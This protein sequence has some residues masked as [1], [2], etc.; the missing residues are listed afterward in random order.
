MRAPTVKRLLLVSYYYPPSPV[1]GAV[2]PSKFAAY[3]PAHGWDP[4][5]VTA[6][7]GGTEARG[8][9][10]AAVHS[11]GEWPHPLK[12]YERFRA[13]RAARHGFA[14]DYSATLIVPF[15]RCYALERRS[16]KQWLLPLFW[17]PD[18]EIGWLGPALLHGLRLIRRHG[19]S[20]LLTTGPPFTCHLVGLLLKWMTGVRWVA[21][22]RDPWSMTHKFPIF[23]NGVT[24]ALESRWIRAVMR[25]ADLVLSVTPA[26]TDEARKDHPDLPPER[27]A[28]LTSGFDAAELAAIQWQ[29]P[30]PLPVIV[31]YFGTFYHGRTP[32]PFLR[33]VKGLLDD[34]TL[35][36]GEMAVRFVGQVSHADGRSITDLVK[37]MGLESVVSLHPTVPR[38]VAL[39]RTLESHIVLVLDERH[40]VQIPLKLYDALGAGV[41]VFNVGSQGAVADVLRR[42]GAG[43]AVHYQ[44]DSE[45]RDGLLECMRRARDSRGRSHEPWADPRIQDFDFQRLTGRLAGHLNDL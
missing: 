18:R 36:P 37:I 4:I 2:R 34:G 19:L 28:T 12:S 26:M 40:P 35:A 43:I 42:T 27:F 15:D 22:F 3:L 32:E 10:A 24:D 41:T 8:A 21:D 20:H 39:K 23:R 13:R 31:S 44:R 33:S 17:L 45:I 6:S 1:V 16:L 38:A 29:P 25:H 11:V 14:D 30:A 9:G 7:T 5:V